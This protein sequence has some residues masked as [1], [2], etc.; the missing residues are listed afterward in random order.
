MRLRPQLLY[1]RHYASLL[2]WVCKSQKRHKP[3][4]QRICGNGVSTHS[5]SVEKGR[6]TLLAIKQGERAI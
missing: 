3:K 6:A 5:I 4:S 1:S 2:G